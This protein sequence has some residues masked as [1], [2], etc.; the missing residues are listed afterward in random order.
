MVFIVAN[1]RSDPIAMCHKSNS[2]DDEIVTGDG[3]VHGIVRC[4]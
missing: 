3:G 4:V 2:F 1:A